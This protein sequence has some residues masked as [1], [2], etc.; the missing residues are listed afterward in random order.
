M[1][2]SAVLLCSWC[3]DAATYHLVADVDSHDNA[4]AG[5][6]QLPKDIVLN[7]SNDLG[8]AN[9]TC[10]TVGSIALLHVGSNPLVQPMREEVCNWSHLVYRAVQRP[11]LK[12][13]TRT[14][15]H[16]HIH[17]QTSTCT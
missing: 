10:C 17:T 15:T 13:Y 7:W 8:S 6:L 5:I 4:D 2:G 12:T 11:T 14:Y 9:H 16:S 1:D 3:D